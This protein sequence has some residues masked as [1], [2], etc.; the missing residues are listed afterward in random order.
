[1]RDVFFFGGVP[2]VATVKDW[3]R[4][5]WRGVAAPLRTIFF[6]YRTTQRRPPTAKHGPRRLP[7]GKG[8]ALA[9]RQLQWITISNSLSGTNFATKDHSYFSIGQ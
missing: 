8:A 6:I 7:V 9:M 2:M 4:W 5:G 3:S 1:M